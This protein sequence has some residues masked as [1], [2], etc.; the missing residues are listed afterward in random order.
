LWRPDAEPEP[1]VNLPHLDPGTA[2]AFDEV[3]ASLETAEDKTED[4][5]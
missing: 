4:Q 1:D 2:R 5:A 3:D